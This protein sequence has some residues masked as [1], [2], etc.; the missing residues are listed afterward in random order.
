[1]RK[2]TKFFPL[3]ENSISNVQSYL[4]IFEQAELTLYE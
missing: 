1:M 2:E 3:L 4:N